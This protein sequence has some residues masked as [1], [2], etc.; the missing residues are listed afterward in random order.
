MGEKFPRLFRHDFPGSNWPLENADDLFI[1]S[2]LWAGSLI[3]VK[4]E[5][6]NWIWPCTFRP[7][8]IA[9]TKWKGTFS[10]F[11]NIRPIESF[12][13]SCS[14][15]L[16]SCILI[17]Y[18]IWRRS[19]YQILGGRP[20]QPNYSYNIVSFEQNYARIRTIFCQ[21]NLAQIDSEFAEDFLTNIR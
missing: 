18:K 4:G 16:F 19:A 17:W 10:K 9:Y 12:A 20:N 5:L 1:R 14:F 7:M 11:Y 21:N 15:C 8:H 3:V 6:I 2:L 13:I